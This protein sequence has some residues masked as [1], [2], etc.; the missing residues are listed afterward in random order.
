MVPRTRYNL[1]IDIVGIG[2]LTIS[3]GPHRAGAVFQAEQVAS[4]RTWILFGWIRRK[5]SNPQTCV[6]HGIL[7]TVSVK[8]S[9]V[10]PLSA[11]ACRSASSPY[12]VP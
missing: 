2:T 8:E 11:P 1:F 10:C 12:I 5:G 3:L 6:V 7:V 9:S 4:S